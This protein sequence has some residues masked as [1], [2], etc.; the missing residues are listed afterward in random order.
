MKLLVINAITRF[1]PHVKQVVAPYYL[2]I[3][4]AA[5]KKFT[6]ATNSRQKVHLVHDR[7]NTNLG[8]YSHDAAEN[9]YRY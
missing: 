2:T 4:D 9:S 6:A 5:G 3:N 7:N 1:L 8:L